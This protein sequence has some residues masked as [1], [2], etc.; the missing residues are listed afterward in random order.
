MST[1]GV[2]FSLHDHGTSSVQVLGSW[3]D[4][5][6]P[7][8]FAKRMEAGYWRTPPAHFPAG[9]HAYKFLLNGDRWLDDPA[10]PCKTPDGV[11]GFNSVV[12]IAERGI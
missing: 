8:I 2:V 11:S 12:I 6:A 4:W 9:R 3:N 7:G 1:E 5:Q 10:N